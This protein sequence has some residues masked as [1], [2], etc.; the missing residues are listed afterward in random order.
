MRCQNCGHINDSN[1]KFCEKCGT[2]L[3]KAPSEAMSNTTKVLIIAVVILV[4][5]LGLVSGMMLM[6]NQAKP[7]TNTTVNNTN[8]NVS[9]TPTQTT[10]SGSQYKTFSNGVIYF[11][12]PS[13]WNVLPNTANTMAIVGFSSYPA[14]S[15]YDESKYGHTSLSDYSSH[16]KS[17]MAN[18]GYS[19]RSEQSRIV[20]G[21]PA[22]E[23]LYQGK[24]GDGIMVIQQMELVEKSPGSQYFALVGVD[25]VDHFDQERSTFNQIVNSFKFLS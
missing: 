22:D 24:T 3:N 8:G 18:N 2:N 5:S 13:N 17:Q 7:I 21:F 10:Q 1:A 4:G 14:F 11:Q 15:V 6:N 9:G 19:V 25:T 23:I 12:Y 16:S 20:N